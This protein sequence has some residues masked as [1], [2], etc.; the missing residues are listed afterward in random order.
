MTAPHVRCESVTSS[1]KVAVFS[2]NVLTE[3]ADVGMI[4]TSVHN[5]QESKMSDIQIAAQMRNE[6]IS[7]RIKKCGSMEDR[8][9]V[10]NIIRAMT[11]AEVAQEIQRERG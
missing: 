7:M 1:E 10:T 11:F 4:P 5:I 2:E 8:I 3:N 9:R 6:L